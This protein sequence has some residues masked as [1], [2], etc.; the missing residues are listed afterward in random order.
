MR[1][2]PF[3]VA[4]LMKCR[5]AQ[6]QALA[7][8]RN[9]VRKHPAYRNGFCKLELYAMGTFIKKYIYI[10]MYTHHPHTHI[11]MY[12]LVQYFLLNLY[13]PHFILGD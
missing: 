12:I 4:P 3:S 10:Y 8:F 9:G 1:G 13:H 2:T 11:Y 7:A 6:Q 5:A